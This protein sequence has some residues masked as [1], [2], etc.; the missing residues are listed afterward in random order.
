MKI[1]FKAFIKKV[2]AFSVKKNK[3][4]LFCSNFKLKIVLYI[5]H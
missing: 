4:S 1:D 3:T 5:K 2:I